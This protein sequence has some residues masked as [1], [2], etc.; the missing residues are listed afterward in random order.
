[1]MLSSI[2]A[3]LC[4]A[5]SLPPLYQTRCAEATKNAGIRPQ[6]PDFSLASRR[7]ERYNDN[8]WFKREENTMKPKKSSAGIGAGICFVL[9]FLL[10][11]LFGALYALFEGYL[12]P[13]LGSLGSMPVSTILSILLTV[14]LGI[15]LM[16]DLRSFA[17]A[18]PVA[19][20]AI[21]QLVSLIGGG[22]GEGVHKVLYILYVLGWFLLTVVLLAA[23]PKLESLRSAVKKIFFLPAILIGAYVLDIL[24]QVMGNW[25]EYGRYLAFVEKLYMFMSILPYVLL[26]VGA[27]LAGKWAVAE[28]E[29]PLAQAG[30]APQQPQRQAYQQPQYQGYQQP[31]YQNYQQPQPQPYQQP[32]YQ[33]YQ[34]PQYQAYQQPQ[35]QNPQPN[36]G[37]PQD[38]TEVLRRFKGLLDDGII[39]QEEFDAKKKQLLG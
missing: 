21:L 27:L 31:Q 11:I 19:I 35:Q 24:I 18:S 15:L 36:P 7:Q 22:G 33:N 25:L 38:P 37:Q 8:I 12:R 3:G 28:R 32:Q 2:S 4:S 39:T 26:A 14:I 9:S 17:T 34:Q 13:Y 29:N 23:E 30:Q 1:M 20:F 6:L 10:P 5:A 16:L